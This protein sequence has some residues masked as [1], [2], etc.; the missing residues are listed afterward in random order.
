MDIFLSI[1]RR[2]EV[3]QLPIVPPELEVSFPWGNETFQTINQGEIKMIGLEGLKSITIESF[4]P[5]KEYPFARDRTYRSWEYVSIIKRWMRQRVP[6]RVVTTN[7]HLPINL[8][9][10][11]DNFSYKSQDGSGDV[12]YTLSLSEFKFVKYQRRRGRV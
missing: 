8:P 7:T 9:M 4:F 6:I 3:I 11:I 2:E 12:Y 10:T 1:N 5:A